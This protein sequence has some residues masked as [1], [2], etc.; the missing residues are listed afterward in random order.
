MYDDL[1][2]F[3]YILVL[4]YTYLLFQDLG[5]LKGNATLM[6]KIQVN[7]LKSHLAI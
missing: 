5:G 4:F 7:H 2:T 3:S 1:L 6:I